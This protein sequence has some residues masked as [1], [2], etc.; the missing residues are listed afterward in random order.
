MTIT[1][2]LKKE[3]EYL[4]RSYEVYG[5]F[6]D[7]SQNYGLAT[8]ESD[9][10]SKALVIPS[11]TDLVLG[12]PVSKTI[13]FGCG[14]C[15]VKDIREMIKNYKKQNVNFLETLYTVYFYVN[16]KYEAF[17]NQLLNKRGEIT[18]ID[19][20][21]ALNAMNGMLMQAKKRMLNETEKTK[22]DIEK[23]G[24]HRKSFLNIIKMAN[25]ID[26]YAKGQFYN[27]VL[28]CSNLKKYRNAEVSK[29]TA[30]MSAEKYDDFAAKTIK[31]Y[32]EE[33]NPAID[34][35]TSKWLDNWTLQVIHS[36]IPSK[37]NLP[38]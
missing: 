23:Y 36:N 19:E 7:G 32:I 6:L 3:Y 16:P 33:K 11:Y 25:M 24:Y 31:R 10:D 26:K 22:A 5:V 30:L 17:H 35:E 27:D 37:L 1:E 29:M 21:R 8:E 4:S 28:D 9:L 14:E 20:K 13:D 38:L 2:I 15:D 12:T 34:E 18:H